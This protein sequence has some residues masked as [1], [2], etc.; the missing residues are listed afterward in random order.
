M[1]F[2]PSARWFYSLVIGGENQTKVQL[3]YADER[4]GN[5]IQH[6]HVFL[7]FSKSYIML[8]SRNSQTYQIVER[9]THSQ[10]NTLWILARLLAGHTRQR[11]WTGLWRKWNANILLVP[12]TK[13]AWHD[14]QFNNFNFISHTWEAWCG[15]KFSMF[16]SVSQNN[17]S[18]LRFLWSH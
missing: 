17:L 6:V 14:I 5:V 18:H 13:G 16:L 15:T 8:N 11:Y 7:P 1:F 9:E 3:Y 4:P 10:N 2:S 12:S